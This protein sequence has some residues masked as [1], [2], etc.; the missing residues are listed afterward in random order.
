MAL[1]SR[2]QHWQKIHTRFDALIAKD[3]VCNLQLA[4][5]C[6]DSAPSLG[7]SMS[8]HSITWVTA[9]QRINC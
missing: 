6:R 2:I 3:E 9:R 4:N 5:N 1:T 8:H 7:S